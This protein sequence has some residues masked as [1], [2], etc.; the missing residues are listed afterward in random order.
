MRHILNLL[1]LSVVFI[2]LLLP[3]AAQ[4]RATATSVPAVLRSP[5]P[6][7]SQP[8][9][10]TQAPTASPTPLPAVRLQALA[11]AGNVNIRNLPSL[12]SEILGTIAAGIEHQVLR[13]FYRWYEFRYDISPTGRAWVYGDLVEI[14]GDQSKIVVI[15]NPADIAAPAQGQNLGEGADSEDEQR[16]IAISAIRAN[17]DQ[18]VELVEVTA[19]PTFTPPAATP[20]PLTD[21]R[22][23][24]T[25]ESQPFTNLPPIVPIA[26]LGALG[27]LGFL[28]SAIRR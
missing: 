8:I 4:A 7:S 12:E 25:T 24:Q 18:S 14:V 5:T 9:V 23:F 2:G 10:P 1:I 21:Q 27:I 6:E 13:S 19:L 22:A 26:V 17:T 20:V 28:A 15:D 11:S 3:V 16:T